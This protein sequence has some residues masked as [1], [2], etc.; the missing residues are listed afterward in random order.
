MLISRAPFLGLLALAVGACALAPLTPAPTQA[1]GTALPALV[2]ATATPGPPTPTPVQLPVTWAGLNLTGSLVFLTAT[3]SLESNTGLAPILAQ[4]DLRTGALRTLFA[5]PP[6]ALLSSGSLAPDGTQLALAYAPPT[7]NGEIQYGYLGIYLLPGDGQG[8]PRA[9]LDQTQDKH[10]YFQPTWSPDSAYIYYTH[11]DPHLD[12][13]GYYTPTYT[14]ERWDVPAG[15]AETIVAGAYW[16]RLSDDGR[17][18]AYVTLDAT[19]THN[20]LYVAGPEGQ[21]ARRLDLPASLIIDVPLFSPDGQ[22]IYFSAADLSF[23]ARNWLDRLWG[24]QTAEAADNPH[25]LPADWWRVPTAGG[26]AE[27]IIPLYGTALYGAFSPDGRHLAF[28]SGE[29]VYVV[30]PTGQNLTA[31]VTEV[32]LVGTLDWRP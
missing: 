17:Q 3:G 5:A 1:T 9:I 15:R 6:G 11:Y 21:A 32:P 29:G 10:A 7:A 23:P 13:N 26:P 12:A 22:W 28:V 19:N 18:L 16:P 8:E 25:S 4:L 27:Q 2:T 20:E 14:V 31:L 30:D 24:V